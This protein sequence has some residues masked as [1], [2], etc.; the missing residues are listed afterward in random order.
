MLISYIKIAFVFTATKYG[1]DAFLAADLAGI[2]SHGIQRMIRYDD[3]ISRGMVDVKAVPQVVLS[4]ATAIPIAVGV[5]SMQWRRIA[6]ST[7]MRILFFGQRVR[8]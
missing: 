5:Y 3:A 8:R 7:T 6:D 2:E 4:T 1:F